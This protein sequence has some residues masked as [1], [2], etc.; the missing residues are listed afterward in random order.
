MYGGMA[1]N[2]LASSLPQGEFCPWK[3]LGFDIGPEFYLTKRP[4]QLTIEIAPCRPSRRASA[5]PNRLHRLFPVKKSCAFFP[6]VFHN[7]CKIC[8]IGNARRSK[9]KIVS[10]ERGTPK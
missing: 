7:L 8:S 5:P 9:V 6:R 1:V 3:L 4:A 10:P 2:L